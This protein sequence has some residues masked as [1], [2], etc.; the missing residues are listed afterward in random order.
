[1]KLTLNCPRALAINFFIVLTTTYW[2]ELHLG[3]MS[4]WYSPFSAAR[5]N[6]TY[7]WCDTRGS[8]SV[9]YCSQAWLMKMVLHV[10]YLHRSNKW[11]VSSR[12]QVE[13]GPSWRY[14]CKEEIKQT[15]IIIQ[16]TFLHNHDLPKNFKQY[17]SDNH[18]N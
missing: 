13:G 17:V 16:Y 7:H 4:T 15:I 18:N 12:V 3:P 5:N 11:S 1:M 8:V 10:Y 6:K 2:R 14:S 9:L